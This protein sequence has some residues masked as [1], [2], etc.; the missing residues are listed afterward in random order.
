MVNMILEY[1]NDEYYFSDEHDCVF[2]ISN[3]NHRI[4]FTQI[5]KCVIK[6]FDVSDDIAHSVVFNWLLFN[7]VQLVKKNWNKTYIVHNKGVILNYATTI[8]EDI[9]FEYKFYPSEE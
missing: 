6:I 3:N 4:G 5:E 2:S 7:G 1:L 8:T 9:D